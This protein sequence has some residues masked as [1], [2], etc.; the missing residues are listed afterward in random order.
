VFWI[1]VDLKE[2]G[3]VIDTSIFQV[4]QSRILRLELR[5][6]PRTG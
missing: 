5:G 6:C 1:D 3:Q 4:G 2:P